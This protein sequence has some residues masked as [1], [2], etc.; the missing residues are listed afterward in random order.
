MKKILV[1]TDF[2]EDSV[3]AYR[4][5]VQMA[6]ERKADILLVFSTNGQAISLTNQMQY[7][8]MLHSFAKRYACDSRLK[9]HPY[10]TECLI[11]GEKWL[12]AVPQIVQ[13]H[14]PDLVI[15]AANLLPSF[16]ENQQTVLLQMQAGKPMIW[17]PAKATYKPIKDLVFVTDFTDQDPRIKDQVKALVNTFNARLTLVHFYAKSYRQQLAEIKKEGLLLREFFGKE[18]S[19]SLLIEEEDM[20]EGLE[21]FALNYPVD[22]F[23]VATRD[24]HLA[25]QYF[26][27]VYRKTN[28]CQTVIPLAN[29]YQEKMKPC[30]GNCNFCHQP[31]VALHEGATHIK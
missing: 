11:T 24:S 20:I 6:C 12:S 25:G 4:Y 8:Q 17:V 1:L 7:S 29:L 5:A 21:D 30:A 3:N 27:P 31:Q 14:Q 13:H 23:L 22:L 19:G 18:I 26:Q 15:A 2:S 16:S 10:H 9:T 28:S